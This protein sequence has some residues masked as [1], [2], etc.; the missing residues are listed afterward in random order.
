MIRKI[1]CNYIFTFI[2][3]N[4]V[5]LMGNSLSDWISYTDKSGIS[6][7]ICTS[8]GIYTA[9]TGGL[10]IYHPITDSFS[11]L[12]NAD[13]LSGNYLSVL[14]FD[15]NDYLWMGSAGSYLSIQSDQNLIKIFDQYDGVS[16]IVYDIACDSINHSAYVTG[17]QGIAVFHQRQFVTRITSSN[18]LLNDQNPDVMIHKDT[19]WVLSDSGLC[20]APLTLNL[21]NPANWK[22]LRT[23]NRQNLTLF[24][25]M[26][27]FG[28]SYYLLSKNRILSF[29]YRA[30]VF[31]LDT[32]Y[33]FPLSYTFSDMVIVSD[34]LYITA[35]DG[36]YAFPS[37]N[38]DRITRRLQE[39][40][41]TSLSYDSSRH[42]LWLGSFQNGLSSY[43][44]SHLQHRIH[45][46]NNGPISNIIYDIDFDPNG[47]V[48]LACGQDLTVTGKK[49]G[50]SF[51]KN[52]QWINEHP[53]VYYQDIRSVAIDQQNNWWFG[54]FGSGLI[55]ASFNQDTI[56]YKVYDHTNSPL[57]GQTPNYVPIPRIIKDQYSNI[58]ISNLHIGLFI[59]V[60]PDQNRWITFGVDGML[61]NIEVWAMAIYYNDVWMGTR[62]HGIYHLNY[63]R[64]ILTPDPQWS[65]T[66]DANEDDLFTNQ[67][68]D[69]SIDIQ[70][71]PWVGT[72]SGPIFRYG[73]AWYT[74]WED[75]QDMVKSKINSI[76]VDEYNNK[77]Y[78]TDDKGLLVAIGDTL[79]WFYFNTRNSPI[80]SN[81]IKRI[82][83]HPITKEIY[84]A[85]DKGLNVIRDPFLVPRQNQ[86]SIRIYPNPFHLNTYKHHTVFFDNLT[87]QSEICVFTI[88]G[89]LVKKL[90]TLSGTIGK[91]VWDGLDDHQN[92]VSPGV[93]LIQIMD[94]N[95]SIKGKKLVI[96]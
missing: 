44:L 54:S 67:I 50:I 43:D 23:I 38:P 1:K 95:H 88:D 68:N 82:K 64:S 93:Y 32:L 85:T 87:S 16:E 52:G 20:Y 66:N 13:G 33:Q 25:K 53:P 30:P 26:F 39:N 92:P 24:N 17:N 40:Q 15:E 65:I 78:G 75:P 46:N 72:L 62:S 80:L 45:T 70:G 76:Y 27:Y 5:Q 41:L 11:W 58:W 19:L 21:S 9:T 56:Q 81:S 90:T 74:P 63:G 36:L 89:T 29:Q 91:I 84:L 28:Q 14:T 42:C 71:N 2:L 61:N 47:N 35:S 59:P 77:Y 69:I 96:K 22:T 73:T 94:A 48:A 60:D 6:D 4:L 57:S 7:V 51:F 55:K 18:G 10:S 49:G 37:S 12:T 8:R 86:D 34:T 79:Q 31:E 83:I 3:C